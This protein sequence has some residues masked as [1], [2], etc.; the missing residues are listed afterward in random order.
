M[1]YWNDISTIFFNIA[2]IMRACTS[3]G[4]NT[5]CS[6]QYQSSY[7][8][9]LGCSGCVCMLHLEGACSLLWQV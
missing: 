4:T 1:E 6:Y 3:K 7:D 2:F 9:S 8:C 5:K